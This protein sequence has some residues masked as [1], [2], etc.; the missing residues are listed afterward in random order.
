MRRL[1]IQYV[2]RPEAGCAGREANRAG[3]VRRVEERGGSWGE[4]SFP[5]RLLA[6]HRAL[7][8]L[9]LLGRERDR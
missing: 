7:Y 3:A 9:L 2:V 1:I 6:R 5:P 8:C 4:T